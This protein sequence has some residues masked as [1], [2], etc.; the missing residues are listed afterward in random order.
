MKNYIL[1]F[2]IILSLTNYALAQ[3]ATCNDADP[4]LS[5]NV[6]GDVT[7]QGYGFTYTKPSEQTLEEEQAIQTE[8]Q[9]SQAYKEG[10][11]STDLF[12]EQLAQTSLISDPAVLPYYGV[13]KD[14]CQYKN[15][16][17]LANLV[18]GLLQGGALSRDEVDTL[19]NVLE[20][21]QINL[22]TYNASS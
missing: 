14:L 15:F 11:F 7:C 22:S 13:V 4:Q 6:N 9:N 5:M 2:L 12:V 8:Y 21:Q 3:N 16:Q 18:A 10:N 1:I 20:N 19:S 17:G